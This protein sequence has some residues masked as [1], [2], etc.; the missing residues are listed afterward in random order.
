MPGATYEQGAPVNAWLMERFNP[1]YIVP[2][3]P[4]FIRP[5]LLRPGGH[6][7]TFIVG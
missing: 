7:S 2:P 1:A 3:D 6:N 4:Q 5:E